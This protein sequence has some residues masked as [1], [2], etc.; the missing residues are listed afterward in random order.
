MAALA[1][2]VGNLSCLRLVCAYGLR[3]GAMAPLVHAERPPYVP[4]F[5]DKSAEETYPTS[6]E[7]IAAAAKL[8]ADGVSMR[9]I[10]RRLHTTFTRVDSM[11]RNHRDLFPRRYRERGA[12]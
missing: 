9:E 7:T 6:D 2:Q 5:E 10:A 3:E 4:Y 8:W 12:A 1:A 11:S